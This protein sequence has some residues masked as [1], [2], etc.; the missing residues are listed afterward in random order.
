MEE[1]DQRAETIRAQI[2]DIIKE[3]PRWEENIHK[4][5]S[6]FELQDESE[7]YT[8]LFHVLCD[9]HIEKEEA[10]ELYQTILVRRGEMEEK[11]ERPIPFRVAML[12]YFMST[13]AHLRSPKVIEIK[14][15]EMQ[16]KLALID[17][18]T[19][20]YN[21]RYLDD[22]LMKE[23]NRSS[24]HGLTFCLLFL[25]ID[26]FKKI[27]DT[28]GH[29]IGDV[30]LKEFARILHEEIRSEDTVARFGGEEFVVVMPETG[31]KGAR[32]LG[33]R[34]L[35]RVR[36][37]PFNGDLRVTFSG[38]IVSYPEHGECV[39]ELIERADKTLYYT[40]Y[41]GKNAVNVYSVEKRYYLR[42]N[43]NWEVLY[44]VNGECRKAYT[45]NISQSGISFEADAP[46]PLS[47]ELELTLVVSK[48]G[49]CAYNIRARVVWEK[50][51]EKKSLYR[52][53]LIFVQRDKEVMRDLQSAIRK[54]H[55]KTRA[56]QAREAAGD[57]AQ[58]SS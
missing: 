47:E 5:A 51:L 20:T 52:L 58:T 36:A 8:H 26:D 42:Y 41:T 2:L 53:G 12:D 3:D 49:G 21:K 9:I 54:L 23:I 46:L 1:H 35:E 32:I 44:T 40:K 11:L 16:T 27:N 55:M 4:E 28:Q 39:R 17:D 38:G 57:D 14:M 37:T 10:H 19:E 30:V 31:V 25:D 22:Y 48:D 24:R 29:Y 15:Y 43:F 45:H 34:I 13:E 6:K 50:E 18:L 56:Y 33:E 7:I